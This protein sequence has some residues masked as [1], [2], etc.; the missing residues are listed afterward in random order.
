MAMTTFIRVLGCLLMLLSA[1][2]PAATLKAGN[3]GVNIDAGNFGGFTLTYPVLVKNG[4]H[5]LKA[6]EKQIH[7]NKAVLK[8]DGGASAELEVKE[9]DV[10]FS[11]SNLPADVKSFRMEMMIDFNFSGGGKW[12][13]GS[14]EKEFPAEKPAKPFLF[15]GSAQSFVLTSLEGKQLTFTIPEFSYQQLQDNREWNW[16]TFCWWF[17]A[18]LS[19][20]KKTQTI[21]IVEGA[22]E[23][24]IKKVVLV[25]SLGQ[26][27]R[28]D[29]PQK[30]KSVDELKADVESEKAYYTNLK[31]PEFDRYGGLPAS[32]EK[33]GL[34]KTGFFHVEKKDRR[35]LLADPDGNAFFHLGVCCFGA[36]DDYTYIKGR[37][38]V[39]EWL[40]PYEGEFNKAFHSEKFWSHDA[41]SFYLANVIR[42]YGSYDSGELAARMIER[43]RKFGF[44]SGGAF[45][46]IPKDKREAASF[47][48]V[49]SL[50]L[51]GWG[52]EPLSE[53]VSQ[54]LDPFDETNRVNIDKRFAGL[55]QSA[56]DPLLI[57]YFLSNEPPHE[58]LPRAVPAADSKHACKRRLVQTLQEKYKT[59]DAF[60]QAW[61]TKIESFEKAA[62]TVLP[63]KTP[64]AAEDM[65]N[66]CAIFWD[67]YYKLIAETFHKY[68][69]HHMLIG[70]RWQPHT[71]NSEQ[72]VAAAG[73][74]MDV[75][76][77]NYY[78]YGVDKDFLNRIYKWSGDKPMFLSEF[79]WSSQKESGLP[80]G[81]DVS[82]QEE[83]GLAYRN[84]VEQS[85]TLG[86]VV[87]IEWFT[88]IDQ[89]R[90]GRW[91]QKYNGENANSGIF[92]VTDRPWKKMVEE[93]LKTNYE[94]YKVELGERAPYVID[95]PRYTMAE[96]GHKSIVIPRAPGEIKIDGRMAGWP[97]VPPELISSK[98]VVEGP[99]GDV[100]GAFRLCWD[101]HNLYFMIDVVDPTPMK[102]NRKGAELW[103]GDAIELF[104]GSE[105]L[106]QAGGLLFADRQ[107]L[108][109]AGTVDGKFQSHVANAPE[110]PAI[111]MI[112]V[113]G[114]DGKSYTLEAAIPWTALNVKPEEGRELLLDVGVDDSASGDS[115]QRQIM[116]NGSAKNSGDRSYW[117]RAKLGQ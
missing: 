77:V 5:Q 106:E 3:D 15:Q 56:S 48:V 11:F 49:S 92:S 107:I 91:F 8:F 12:K 31:P 1:S 42:K 81:K 55:A 37:E 47:P 84:Y 14:S 95:N 86:Y 103:Q 46:G 25:D 66:Y 69:T 45:S 52:G 104:I 109:S 17:A 64:A 24:G 33:L 78:T 40:P 87:G 26:D 28:T 20:D 110:Q 43:V 116:W 22:A 2:L 89:A 21:K 80:G 38:S 115:R 57:G 32:A 105:K 94:I 75:I 76:S 23:G 72:L 67:E 113:A 35:W 34:A 60:N 73:R 63:V 99:A 98:R 36:S 13:I 18:P 83:R 6:I 41:F 58:D 4:D 117:G 111:Q 19:P 62:D 16:K 79:Y 70:N 9:H 53:I 101:S 27:V 50:P 100:A 65:K 108:L 102:N 10:A 82:G 51:G 61:G 44:N 59:A 93:M 39:Y 71:A 90:T 97:G 30:V 54:T 88:L 29:F 85:A 112:V 7:G 74:Y 114:I 68:D 96:G